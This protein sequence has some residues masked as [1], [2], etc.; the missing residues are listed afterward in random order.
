MDESL[1][2]EILETLQLVHAWV[3]ETVMVDDWISTAGRSYD[4][5]QTRYGKQVLLIK[6]FYVRTS[7]SIATIYNENQ[8]IEFRT[9][10]I[11]TILKDEKSITFEIN[12]KDQVWRKIRISRE[13]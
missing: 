9:D 10:S 4:R 6:E 3:G 2:Q 12:M 1:K 7:G 8:Q 11:K 13:D 5:H